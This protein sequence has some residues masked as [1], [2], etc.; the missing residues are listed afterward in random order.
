MS[1]DVVGLDAALMTRH[2]ANLRRIGVRA[3]RQDYLAS[4]ER[5]DGKE[6]ADKL[7][8]AFVAD[9]E[10]RQVAERAEGIE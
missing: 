9:W 5:A 1:A 4:V 7:R 6:F 3:M 10:R 8:A 2:I